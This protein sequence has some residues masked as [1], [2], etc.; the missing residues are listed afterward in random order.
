MAGARI[1][2]A[3][4]RMSMRRT[5][6][7]I[8]AAG[9]LMGS[10]CASIVSKS[11]WPVMVSSKPDGAV[12]T[13]Q[14][15]QGTVISKATTPTIF[16]L[17]S[18]DGFFRSASYTLRFE[19]EGYQP[20]STELS[21]GLNGW[22]WGNIIFGGLIG[23]L[24]V[25]PATGAMWRLDESVTG[26]MAALPAAALPAAGPDVPAA[27][28]TM[29]DAPPAEAQTPLPQSPEGPRDMSGSK[30]AAPSQDAGTQY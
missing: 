28:T 18:G 29:P 27:E 7:L 15:K 5:V 17:K 20:A 10:G 26:T 9:M 19:K 8:V 2:S 1:K 25:D 6:G 30:E 3:E 23:M 24:I 11:D 14:N 22:Y 4:R 12:C 13:V 21:T 16:L